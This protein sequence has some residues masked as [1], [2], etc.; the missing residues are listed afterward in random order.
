MS[1]SFSI[2]QQ[3][4]DAVYNICITLHPASFVTG[5][6]EEKLTEGLDVTILPSTI[7]TKQLYP[8]ASCVISCTS[9][10]LMQSLALRIPSAY[11]FDKTT[12]FSNCAIESGIAPAL[13]SS[14]ELIDWL[15]QDKKGLE[16]SIEELIPPNSAENIAHEIITFLD[17]TD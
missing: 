11:L 8:Y 10:T 15:D 7:S 14:Q 3:R 12:P 17:K 2:Q 13:H 4:L 5:A 6:F 9:S 16:C 1:P